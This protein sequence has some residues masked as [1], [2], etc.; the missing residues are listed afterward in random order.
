M[1]A[2]LEKGWALAVPP[3]PPPRFPTG[4]YAIV[5]VD[6]VANAP[7]AT[8]AC[9]NV[10][11][12][13]KY[14]NCYYLALL[15]NPAV[16]GLALQIHW[17]TLNPAEPA[18]AGDPNAYNWHNLQ[19]AF[20][21][22]D[23]WNTANPSLP[24]TIQLL[25][26]PGFFTPGWV[27]KNLDSCD[28]LFDS[29]QPTATSDCGKVTFKGFTECGDDVGCN[30]T[31]KYPAC[32]NC[33]ELPMPWNN[34]YQDA[35]TGFLQALNA[36]YG[37][38]ASLVSIAVAGPTAS[39]VEMILPNDNNSNVPDGF[40]V[41]PASTP[42]NMWLG[43]LKHKNKGT[44]PP[45]PDDTFVDEWNKAIDTY[46]SV[47][48]GLTLVVTTGSGLPD[49]AVSPETSSSTSLVTAECSKS[50]TNDCV[51]EATILYHFAGSGVGGYNGK[52]TQS[53]GVEAS[54][55]PDGNLG[56]DGVKSLTQST[57]SMFSPSTLILGGAQFNKPFSDSAADTQAEGCF[58][59]LSSILCSSLTAEQA[60]YDALDVFFLGTQGVNPL[61]GETWS[62]SATLGSAPLNYLQIYDDDIN[63]ATGTTSTQSVVPYSF[64]GSDFATASLGPTFSASAQTLL[65]AVRDQLSSIAKAEPICPL[66]TTCR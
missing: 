43:L 3:P 25:V 65:D 53:S 63:Y 58:K 51:A 14:L 31:T 61:T 1:L 44:A 38:K 21:S 41:L 37:S 36:Q 34:D 50:M 40:N 17:D 27:M 6:K 64:D 35:W 46:A 16:A 56:L 32:S 9:P 7:A 59:G 23:T 60:A 47:F 5:R 22:V 19:Y 26:S 13:D 30:T 12:I 20:D 2:P 39:S 49:L 11:H 4:I 29:S 24:K 28:G 15:G 62:F 54:R 45:Y 42:D 57:M 33:Y 10:K 18:Y 8:T 52:A 66:G 48:S 55:L